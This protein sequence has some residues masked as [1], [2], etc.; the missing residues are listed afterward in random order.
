MQREQSKDSK[1]TTQLGL[2][3]PSNKRS[4]NMDGED[5]SE[6]SDEE[7]FKKE[8]EEGETPTPAV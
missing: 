8:D 2:I 7:L 6:D 5:S 3:P 1:A 4:K